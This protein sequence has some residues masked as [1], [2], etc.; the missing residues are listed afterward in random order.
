LTVENVVITVYDLN[1]R[2]VIN[3][4]EVGNQYNIDV[5]KI[6]TGIYLMKITG[7]DKTEMI[8]FIKN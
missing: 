1:G 2:I 5:N 6:P 4:S 7:S 3:S 8:K